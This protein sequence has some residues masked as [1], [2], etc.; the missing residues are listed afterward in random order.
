MKV[1][2]WHIVFFIFTGL[3][4]IGLLMPGVIS[5]AASVTYELNIRHSNNS[6][7]KNE[8]G[9]SPE[10]LKADFNPQAETPDTNNLKMNDPL[11]K[12][13]SFEHMY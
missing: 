9:Q 2:F 10:S 7:I 8:G 5:Q 1:K 4:F 6:E 3:M 13:G 11:I 12:F